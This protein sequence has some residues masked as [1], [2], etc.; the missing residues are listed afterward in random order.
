[1]V[2]GEKICESHRNSTFRNFKLG[3][4]KVKERDEYD[5]VGCSSMFINCNFTITKAYIQ[6]IEIY[7][8]TK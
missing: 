6:L 7:G 5:H 8:I 3:I 2:Y 4:D 1:M